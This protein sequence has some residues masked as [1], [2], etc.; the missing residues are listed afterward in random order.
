MIKY[1]CDK[2]GKEIKTEV[3]AIPMYARDRFG[4]AICFIR[5]NH[6]CEECAKQFDE[7]QDHLEY[8]EDFFN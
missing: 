5:Y 1:F 3:R 7:I 2:C 8:E 4:A 6:I